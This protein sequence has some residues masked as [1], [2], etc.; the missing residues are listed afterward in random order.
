M[1][2]WLAWFADCWRLGGC[3]VVVLHPSGFAF[4]CRGGCLLSVVSLVVGSMCVVS[5]VLFGVLYS[6]VWNFLFISLGWVMGSVV[7]GFC[8][9]GWVGWLVYLGFVAKEGSSPPCVGLC[10]GKLQGKRWGPSGCFH[11]FFWFPFLL[12]P[13]TLL[14]L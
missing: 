3:R 2:V 4:M 13:F 8:C 14:I 1:M 10:L 12:F 5:A 6:D 9:A 7:S 11:F